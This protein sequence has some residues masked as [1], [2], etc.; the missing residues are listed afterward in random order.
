MEN[1][2]DE[3]AQQMIFQGNRGCEYLLLFRVFF[4]YIL[5][6]DNLR[7][8]GASFQVITPAK[9]RPSLLPLSSTLHFAASCK[10]VIVRPV[11][12]DEKK[13]AARLPRSL[14]NISSLSQILSRFNIMTNENDSELHTK[15]KKDVAKLLSLVHTRYNSALLG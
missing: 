9:A 6:R 15:T 12:S 1:Y 7:H 11:H 2:I 10:Q 5:E 4:T 13:N 3:Y 14:E 8:R